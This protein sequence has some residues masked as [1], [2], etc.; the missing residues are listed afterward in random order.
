MPQSFC[1]RCRID[2][3]RVAEFKRHQGEVHGVKYYCNHCYWVG[4]KRHYRLRAHLKK[5][6][7]ISINSRDE[8]ELEWSLD[9]RPQPIQTMADTTYG[10]GPDHPASPRK[11]LGPFT[12]EV[13]QCCEVFLTSEL[14]FNHYQCTHFDNVLC[15]QDGCRVAPIRKINLGRHIKSKHPETEKQEISQSFI[16]R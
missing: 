5:N 11:T 3:G 9:D 10:A 2:F 6:H 8:I 7:Q 14:R 16:A 15:Q 13:D 1:E 12:C 4:S